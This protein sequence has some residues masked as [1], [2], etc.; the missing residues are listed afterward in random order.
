MAVKS[1][2]CPTRRSGNLGSLMTVTFYPLFYYG[3]LLASEA[4]KPPRPCPPVE[5]PFFAVTAFRLICYILA[6]QIADSDLFWQVYALFERESVTAM[7]NS[8]R[9]RAPRKEPKGG[10]AVAPGKL[11][12][13]G[14]DGI[15]PTVQMAASRRDLPCWRWDCGI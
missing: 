8:P 12:T 9:G 13:Q 10:P 15:G 11:P 3:E 5:K 2:F 6:Q 7:P 1:A 4:K 14:Q